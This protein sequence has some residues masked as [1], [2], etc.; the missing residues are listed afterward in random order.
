MVYG[1]SVTP[2]VTTREFD[3]P[4]DLLLHLVRRRELDVC[5]LSLVEIAGDFSDAIAA[6]TL[7]HDDAAESLVIAATLVEFKSA[8]LL[9]QPKI[10]DVPDADDAATLVDRLLDYARFRDAADAFA[11]LAE[12]AAK[13]HARVPPALPKQEQEMLL[14][15]L[16]PELLRETFARLT[17]DLAKRGPSTHDVSDDEVPQEV[18]R[19]TALRSV[20]DRPTDLEA[21][22]RSGGS[23]SAAVG[24]LLATLEL[25]RDGLMRLSVADGALQLSAGA[26]HDALREPS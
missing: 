23:R 21:M 8:M 16:T 1:A 15:E 22:L 19:A 4:L 18:W 17:A 26:G 24:L 20:A 25:L 6:G 7:D 3:G 13:Q 9:P 5:K 14:D 10:E 2:R 12:S 11:D